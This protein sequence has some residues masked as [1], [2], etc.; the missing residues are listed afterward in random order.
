MIIKENYDILSKYVFECKLRCG[1][2][3]TALNDTIATAILCYIESNPKY[4]IDQTKHIVGNVLNSNAKSLEY[5]LKIAYPRANPEIQKRI[6][7]NKLF[8][9]PIKTN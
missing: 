8:T 9:Q 7:I 1:D 6:D 5:R 3:H 4:T 2:S